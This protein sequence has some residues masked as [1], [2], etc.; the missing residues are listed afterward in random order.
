VAWGIGRI[1]FWS[2]LEP[3]VPVSGSGDLRRVGLVATYE[4]SEQ[5]TCLGGDT[6]REQEVPD[7]R[8]P[9]AAEDEALDIVELLQRPAFRAVF[10][11]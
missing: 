9:V 4:P 7:Y 10:G 5:R 8:H 1:V 3:D 11:A 2:R 6:D